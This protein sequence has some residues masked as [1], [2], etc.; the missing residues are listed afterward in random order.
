MCFL[1][2]TDYFEYKMNPFGYINMFR[3]TLLIICYEKVRCDNVGE[4]TLL[5]P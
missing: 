5:G 3:L 1:K 4:N 2:L